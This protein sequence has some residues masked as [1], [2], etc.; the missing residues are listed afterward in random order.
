MELVYSKQTPR[1]E[2]RGANNVYIQHVHF[3]AG[4]E[5]GLKLMVSEGAEH[6]RG[7]YKKWVLL[8][9]EEHRLLSWGGGG[10]RWANIVH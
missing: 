4:Q 6:A 10:G 2:R 9:R 1:L 8:T 7:S 5:A 3:G